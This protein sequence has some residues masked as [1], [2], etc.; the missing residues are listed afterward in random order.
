MIT[1][2]FHVQLYLSL[3]KISEAAIQTLVYLD[4]LAFQKKTSDL[5]A[6]V[7]ELSVMK[8]K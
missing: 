5:V 6:N 8:Q 1:K 7:L 2:A 4:G 3:L